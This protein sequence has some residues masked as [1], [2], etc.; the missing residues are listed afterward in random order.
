MLI[1]PLWCPNIIFIAILVLLLV[2][3]TPDES[4]QMKSDQKE[5]YPTHYYD[6]QSGK[7]K[8]Y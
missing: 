6:R 4:C 5:D 7:V 3:P 1:D 2:L 8:R